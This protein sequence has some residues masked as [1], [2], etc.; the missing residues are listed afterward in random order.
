MEKIDIVLD[1]DAFNE[2]GDR[3]AIG[4]LMN[5]NQKYMNYRIENVR[6]SG[7]DGFYGDELP[8]KKYV[9]FSI[10]KKILL[11]EICSTN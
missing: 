7:D 4:W 6:L 1:T 10:W 8:D 11:W 3:Y 2:V 9:T 5:D